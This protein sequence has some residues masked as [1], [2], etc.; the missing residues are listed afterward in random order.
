MLTPTA[1]PS[2][3]EHNYI[4]RIDLQ[5]L[6]PQLDRKLQKLSLGD[7]WNLRHLNEIYQKDTVNIYS[8]ISIITDYTPS[9]WDEGTCYEAD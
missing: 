6:T 4:S 1:T 8:P 5:Q 9:K 2:D 3:T 7:L